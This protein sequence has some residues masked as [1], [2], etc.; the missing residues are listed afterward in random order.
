MS[1]ID[2]QP[3]SEVRLAEPFRII[4]AGWQKFLTIA[5]VWGYLLR[6]PS[7]GVL[8]IPRSMSRRCNYRKQ[9][10]PVGPVLRYVATVRQMA[11]T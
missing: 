10:R 8:M 11:L 9:L 7:T 5:E 4:G 2:S 6:V 3:L 1:S